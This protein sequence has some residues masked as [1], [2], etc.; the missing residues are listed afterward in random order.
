MVLGRVSCLA[1]VHFATVFACETAKFQGWGREPPP[2]P[3][4]PREFW[5]P[6]QKRQMRPPP[7][8]ASRKFSGSR[9]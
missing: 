7:S 2:Y 1:E 9:N 5:G 3:G 6:G 4:P 8:E